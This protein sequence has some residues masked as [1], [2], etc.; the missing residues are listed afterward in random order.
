MGHAYGELMADEIK[1][2]LKLFYAYYMG[3]LKDKLV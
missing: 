3:M 1:E 2:T